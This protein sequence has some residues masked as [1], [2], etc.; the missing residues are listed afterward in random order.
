MSVFSFRSGWCSCTECPAPV[1]GIM[2]MILHANYGAS[3]GRLGC[4]CA[5]LLI[6]IIETLLRYLPI[7]GA[8]KSLQNPRGTVNERGVDQL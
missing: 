8:Y 6:H 5:E 1:L 7:L 2:G 4:R 3:F